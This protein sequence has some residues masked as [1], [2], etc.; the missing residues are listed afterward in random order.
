MKLLVS[1]Q[2]LNNQLQRDLPHG[3][4]KDLVIRWTGT[5]QAGQ[6]VTLAQLGQVRVNYRGTDVVNETVNFFSLF[7][8][9]KYGVA[10]FSSIVAGAYAVSIVI[11]F[12]APWDNTVGLFNNAN[13]AGFVELRNTVTIVTVTGGVVQISYVEAN[14]MAPYL[15]YFIQ[16]N[17]AV[18]GAGQQTQDFS[19]TDISSLFIEN[20]VN[21]TNVFIQK[22]QLSRIT[23]DEATLLSYSNFLNRVE[24]AIALL[25]VN[26]NPYNYIPAGGKVTQFNGTFGAA[27]VL[28]IHTMG[29][30]RTPDA[31][32]LS[33]RFYAEKPAPAPVDIARAV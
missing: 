15:T 28:L 8:N 20:N 12:H 11:P 33:S 17:L 29:F 7:N 5:N 21:L 19:G 25:E 26:L 27:T 1:D 9:L 2:V 22:D 23:S 6:A 30:A 3:T 4:I 18:G 24:T 32:Q 31:A 16:Q 13:Y 10:E 14:A